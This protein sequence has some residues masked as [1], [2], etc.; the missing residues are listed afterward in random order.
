MAERTIE[1]WRAYIDGL[2]SLPR[3]AVAIAARRIGVSRMAQTARED[4]LAAMRA[5]V[6][7]TDESS[8]LALVVVEDDAFVWAPDGEGDP[9]TDDFPA[10]LAEAEPEA[11]PPPAAKH[12][13][14][15]FGAL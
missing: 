14:R 6:G 13:R 2:A 4:I 7:L 9:A 11:V 15:I 1:E 3:D 5:H 8:P 10:E 12:R